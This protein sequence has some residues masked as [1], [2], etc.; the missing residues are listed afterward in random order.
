MRRAQD[1]SAEYSDLKEM[2]E[3]CDKTNVGGNMVEAWRRVKPIDLARLSEGFDKQIATAEEALKANPKDKHAKNML[4]ISEALKK[5][6]SEGF[7]YNLKNKK[8]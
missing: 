6:S 8:I 5:M 4:Y 2:Y 3:K 7:N 1:E